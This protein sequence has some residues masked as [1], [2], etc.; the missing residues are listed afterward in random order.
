V[1]I[2]G[3]VLVQKVVFGSK[4][5]KFKIC[6]M[7]SANGAGISLF[8]SLNL[9]RRYVQKKIILNTR[10]LDIRIFLNTILKSFVR[11]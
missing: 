7:S 4:V 11:K 3:K 9:L 2:F 1:N 6:H 5:G 8:N 10:K